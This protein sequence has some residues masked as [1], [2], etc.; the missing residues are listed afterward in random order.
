MKMVCMVDN[1]LRCVYVLRVGAMVT[2]Q[3]ASGK[4]AAVFYLH[5][6]SLAVCDSFKKEIGKNIKE[7]KIKNSVS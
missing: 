2:H 1:K 4:N 6:S 3:E 7:R 5:D